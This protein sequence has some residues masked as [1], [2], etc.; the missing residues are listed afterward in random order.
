M[1]WGNDMDELKKDKGIMNGRGESD[2]DWITVNGAHIP[3]K[4]G[5]SKQD[6]IKKRFDNKPK[7]KSLSFEEQVDCVLKGTY[8]D[9]HITMCEETPEVFQDI[10][11]PNKP[12]LMTSKHAYLAINS[13]GKYKGRNDHYHN[14]G[15]DL[16]VSIP[17][18]LES[19]VMVLKNR[20]MS[21]EVVAVLNWYDKNTNLLI[22][23][24]KIA[25]KGNKDFI[26]I[27]ANI[28]KS[29]YGRM[30]FKNY[31]NNN[32]SKNDILYAGNKKIRNFNH[33]G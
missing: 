19:P 6:V 31:I 18:L 1:N 17:K 10:G 29:A 9:S 14:L 7:H 16:F 30:N 23:P 15:K 3:I 5:E 25:G 12:V 13:E 20:R 22:V 27:E 33:T 26:E 32:F 28:V 8:K 21:N 11:V 4:D 2:V 24:I